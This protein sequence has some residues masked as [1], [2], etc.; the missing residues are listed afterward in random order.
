MAI[1]QYKRCG[2]IISNVPGSALAKTRIS[3]QIPVRAA[4]SA[5]SICCSILDSFT[6]LIHGNHFFNFG[7]LEH[8]SRP[9]RVFN[10]LA[11]LRVIGYYSLAGSVD[12][13]S[14]RISCE[15]RAYSRHQHR[16]A[17][18]P[19]EWLS[20]F[21]QVHNEV[22][23]RPLAALHA[24]NPNLPPLLRSSISR[25]PQYTMHAYTERLHHVSCS[26]HQRLSQAAP[27]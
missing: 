9:D 16:N 3:G 23:R 21:T 22:F 24:P 10:A 13:R 2:C 26:I 8:Q 15:V 20:F 18:P 19:Q 5:G 4:F 12:A 11:L 27:P 25:R 6:L 17:P 7:V 1:V 14:H